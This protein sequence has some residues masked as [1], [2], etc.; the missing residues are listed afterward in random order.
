M[1]LISSHLLDFCIRFE[2]VFESEVFEQHPVDTGHCAGS[3]GGR[4]VN[5][6]GSWSFEAP[7]MRVELT[8]ETKPFRVYRRSTK[9]S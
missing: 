1:A 6:K 4:L 2:G 9:L 7:G 5:A 3:S 8:E